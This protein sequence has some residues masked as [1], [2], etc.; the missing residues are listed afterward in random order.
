MNLNEINFSFGGKHC[1]L[2]YGAL[3][4]EKN[5]HTI[6]PEIARNE[7]DIAGAAGSI[8]MPGALPEE[9]TFSGSLYFLDSPTTQEEAQE[10][11]RRIAAWLTNGRQR[12]IF[13]YEPRYYIASVKGPLK[14]GYSGWIDGGLDVEFAAQPYA[15]ALNETTAGAITTGTSAYLTLTLDTGAPTPLDIDIRNTGAAHITGA[16]VSAGGK[17]A[18]FTGMRIAQGDAL[19]INMTPP[20]GAAF[21]SGENA[22][23]YATRFDAL[24]AVQGAQSVSVSLTYGSGGRGASVTARARGRWM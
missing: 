12:L 13:D 7:Y 23:P 8:L 16:T 17:Q 14:W 3:Y 4:V 21:A 5:G 20:I 22:L 1:L 9:L 19:Q 10:R 6:T 11:L 18:A 2:D 15:W 24:T